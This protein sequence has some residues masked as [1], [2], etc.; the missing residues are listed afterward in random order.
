MRSHSTKNQLKEKSPEAN[1]IRSNTLWALLL[2]NVQK[3]SF[4]VIFSFD[5]FSHAATVH[6]A[7]CSRPRLLVRSFTRALGATL[8]SV[9]PWPACAGVSCAGRSA[10]A[11]DRKQNGGTTPFTAAQTPWWLRVAIS[12]PAHAC[13]TVAVARHAQSALPAADVPVR[14]FRRRL[15]VSPKFC[16]D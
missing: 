8:A 16:Q 15:G 2:F 14:P 13:S 10:V 3:F 4:S 5:S 11:V 1:F 9:A 6:L 7:R 12:L